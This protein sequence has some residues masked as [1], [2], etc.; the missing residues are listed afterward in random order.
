MH[1]IQIC[2][3]LKFVQL[4][5]D[6]QPPVINK[7][8]VKCLNDKSHIEKNKNGTFLLTQPCFGLDLATDFVA[9]TNT[10]YTKYHQKYKT[11]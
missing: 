4:N 6:Q 8:T 3:V 2:L 9:K 10:E 11:T 1:L 7:S 5:L